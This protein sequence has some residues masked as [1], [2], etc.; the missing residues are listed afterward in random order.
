MQ[1]QSTWWKLVVDLRA[2]R[3]NFVLL[4]NE[5]E[6][7]KKLPHNV[8]NLRACQ[9]SFCSK[10]Q[11]RYM[12]NPAMFRSYLHERYIPFYQ[13]LPGCKR[14]T[15]IKEKKLKKRS[16]A[17]YKVKVT[18]DTAC[19]PYESQ[20]PRVIGN[21]S[22]RTNASNNVTASHQC[23]SNI[24]Q[25]HDK[26]KGSQRVPVESGSCLTYIHLG[27]VPQHPSLPST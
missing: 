1:C 10:P 4:V 27:R 2:H 24:E 9:T 15:T 23:S 16:G 13:C 20:R 6:F 21:L 26:G 3:L 14:T 22:T 17:E 8:A 7:E 12:S 25:A 18:S 5:T 11:P 19:S